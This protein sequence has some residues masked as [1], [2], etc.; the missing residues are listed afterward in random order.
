MPIL[1]W[2]KTAKLSIIFFDEDPWERNEYQNE[3]IR[4]KLVEQLI[5]L[6]KKESNPYFKRK[7]AFLTIRLAYYANKKE[8]IK[9]V[10]G[11]LFK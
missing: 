3:S 1:K 5:Q 7:Y 4:E 10:F 8:V 9:S 2:L 11:G 6:T